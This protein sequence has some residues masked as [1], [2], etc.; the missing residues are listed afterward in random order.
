MLSLAKNQYVRL[1]ARFAACEKACGLE[2]SFGKTQ[3]TM[4]RFFSRQWLRN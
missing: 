1:A 3:I 4:K 2:L